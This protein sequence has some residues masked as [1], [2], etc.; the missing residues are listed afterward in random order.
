MRAS[1]AQVAASFIEAK[2]HIAA[3]FDGV[4]LSDI[5]MPGKDGFA[6]LD[7]ARGV[8]PD[9]PVILLAAAYAFLEKPCAPRDLL[10]VVEKALKSRALVLES[11]RRP[12]CA[13]RRGWRRKAEPKS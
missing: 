6:L 12:K 9:L 11:R 4:V 5:R 13:R 3:D 10:A 2:D 7:H 1:L 8:D